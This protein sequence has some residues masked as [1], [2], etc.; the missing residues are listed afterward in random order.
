MLHYYLTFSF[1]LKLALLTQLPT[2]NEKK[3]PPHLKIKPAK[4]HNG[5]LLKIYTCIFVQF[6]SNFSCGKTVWMRLKASPALKGLKTTI[7]AL[8]SERVN[9]DKQLGTL[10]QC[11]LDVGPASQTM[12]QHRANGLCLL[13]IILPLF[14]LFG[15]SIQIRAIN[16]LGTWNICVIYVRDKQ[17]AN[18]YGG[19]LH[20]GWFLTRRLA[21]FVRAASVTVGQ[22]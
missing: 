14:N 18:Y 19:G 8:S 9:I 6:L 13:G 17:C 1:H 2:S 11:W 15:D 10:T 20:G 21:N 4:F 3:I 12:D 7:F 22:H 5:A 16:K